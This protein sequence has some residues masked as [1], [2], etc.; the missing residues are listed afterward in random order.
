LVT[1][2][3]VLF[4]LI[5]IAPGLAPTPMVA[6]MVLVVVSITETVLPPVETYARVPAA[7]IAIR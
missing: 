6:T 3:R 7:F 5:A 2:N 4:G 1:Y